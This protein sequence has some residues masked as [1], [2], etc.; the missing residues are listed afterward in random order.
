MSDAIRYTPKMDELREM[1][2]P[3]PLL[4]VLRE[5]RQKGTHGKVKFIEFRATH[6]AGT[7]AKV[8]F[9]DGTTKTVGVDY[10][11]LHNWLVT[12]LLNEDKARVSYRSSHPVSPNG[13]P[14]FA[15]PPA[16]DQDLAHHRKVQ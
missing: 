15:R 13:D 10:C 5:C 12:D 16:M 2:I 3:Q 9:R 4:Q 7:R 8:T 6:D 11:N 1:N 14:R